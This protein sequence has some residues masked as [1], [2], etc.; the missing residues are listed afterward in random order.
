MSPDAKRHWETEEW[1][2]LAQSF[3]SK[4]LEW[5]IA[6]CNNAKTKTP[7][8]PVRQACKGN[9]SWPEVW[10]QKAG[11]LLGVSLYGEL[12]FAG[13]R[14]AAEESRSGAVGIWALIVNA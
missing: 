11:S 12:R 7:V 6:L 13:S 4:G 1:L 9:D 8:A 14:S 2:V 3:Y 5:P 10:G